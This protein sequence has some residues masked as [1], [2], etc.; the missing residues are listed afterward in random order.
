MAGLR[1]HPRQF[2]RR[3]QAIDGA[4]ARPWLFK[5]DDALDRRLMADRVRSPVAVYWRSSS[6]NPI[7]RSDR[8]GASYLAEVGRKCEFADVESCRSVP[9]CGAVT[10][11]NSTLP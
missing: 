4:R 11:S 1:Q 3:K 9:L 10:A 2:A 5:L 7:R 6:Q 8:F